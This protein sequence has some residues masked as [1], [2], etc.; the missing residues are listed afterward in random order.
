MLVIQVQHLATLIETR[1]DPTLPA[2][3]AVATYSVDKDGQVAHA[4]QQWQD[5]GTVSTAGVKDAI[6]S[7][8]S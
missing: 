7:S 6:V 5:G 8:K 1:S 2:E 3:Y 4:V